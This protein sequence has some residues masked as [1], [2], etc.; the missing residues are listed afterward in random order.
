[1][2]EVRRRCGEH[3]PGNPDEHHRERDEG[4]GNYA[5]HQAHLHERKGGDRA[6]IAGCGGRK[7][8]WRTGAAGLHRGENAFAEGGLLTLRLGV[9]C[10]RV[11]AALELDLQMRREGVGEE[12]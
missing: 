6:V 11:K 5:H 1:M 10:P 3:A 4:S 9:R 7:G 2:P 12:E 8:G